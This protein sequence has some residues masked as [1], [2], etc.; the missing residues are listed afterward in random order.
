MEGELVQPHLDRLTRYLTAATS[1]PDVV[2]LLVWSGYGVGVLFERTG[3]P[4]RVL[5]ALR[6]RVAR[7]RR[8]PA[9]QGRGSAM[10]ISPSLA[11]SGRTYILHRGMID[12]TV[13]TEQH[14][15]HATPPS[16]W[17]PQDHAWFVST[18]IDV[19][20]TYVGGPASLVDAL[21]ADNV[22]E[23]FPA[24]LADRPGGGRDEA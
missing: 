17:W 23:V 7:C 2:W 24:D 1:T 5:G 12:D 20:S 21:L 15:P 3:E 11:G 14:G 8:Q 18:D 4:R 19:P 10:E 16:F 22:L 13:A 9:D 6:R